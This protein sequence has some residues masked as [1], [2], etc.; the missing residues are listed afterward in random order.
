M[1]VPS[2]ARIQISCILRPSVTTAK[3]CY[4]L[5]S[6]RSNELVD[7]EALL[8]EPSWS[9]QSLLSPDE[10]SASPPPP[11]PVT[12]EQL[13]HLLRLSALPLPKTQ[14]EE[15]KMIKD[16]Q[17]QLKFVQAI[18]STDTTNVEPLQS[19]RNET[20]E[21]ERKHTITKEMLKEALE[22]EETVGKR[23]RIRRK[24]I[25]PEAIQESKS[26]EARKWNPLGH[27]ARTQ[28]SYFVVDNA[29]D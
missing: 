24:K 7:V 8:K 10:S 29:K 21:S 19:I 27:A 20:E 26:G 1:L 28:G 22:K 4:R 17:A 9:V 25:L 12:R 23:G 2:I 3:H 6:S 5:Q 18:Q 13:H 16:L 15:A 11:P 14:D